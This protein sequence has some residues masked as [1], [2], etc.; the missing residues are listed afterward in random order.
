MSVEGN[1]ERGWKA[2]EVAW[3]RG[4]ASGEGDSVE[5]MLLTAYLQASQ[6]S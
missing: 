5:G 1:S 6:H 3:G 4:H 2:G